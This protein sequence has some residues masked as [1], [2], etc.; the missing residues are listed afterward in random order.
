MGSTT[1]PNNRWVVRLWCSENQ[2]IAALSASSPAMPAS[3]M[4]SARSWF[5]S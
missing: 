1:E 3:P 4:P 5:A 2:V